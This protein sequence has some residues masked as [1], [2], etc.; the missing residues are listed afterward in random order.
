MT[1]IQQHYYKCGNKIFTSKINALIAAKA[2]GR[3]VD[4][5]F[6]DDI[7]KKYSWDVEPDVSLDALYDIRARELR[8]KY[9]YLIISYSGGSDSHNVVQ[10]FIRQNLHIDELVTNHWS[11]VSKSTTVLDT[12]V[13]ENWNINAE[14]ELQA[15]PR[16]KELSEKLPRTKITVLDASQTI[17]DSMASYDD[18]SWIMNKNDYLSFGHLFRYNYFY[19]NELKKQFDKNL[20]IGVIL[21]A[22][23]P[24]TKIVDNE[25]YVYFPDNAVNIVTIKDHKVG[26]DD[27]DNLT[28]EMFYWG[29]TTA[30][31]VCKQ[32]YVIKRWLEQNPDK[33][34]LWINP[35]GETVRLYHEK[36]M[37]KLLYTTTWNQDWFQ[38][39]KS[40]DWW[41]SQFDY[42]NRHPQ[43]AKEFANWERGIN[44][45]A[46]HLSEWIIL[47]KDNKPDRFKTFT[48]TYK[49]GKMHNEKPRLIV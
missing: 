16:L 1:P 17:L 15:M 38:T 24:R 19:F 46:K 43:F 33:Q 9:D 32:A 20:K 18:E 39:D 8:E 31:I 14:H 42:W 41:Y 21:G 5:L 48:K 27:H 37:R 13:T 4:W 25:F 34:A 40:T 49:I 26:N 29:E 10:S 28:V 2:T 47:N 11:G 7:Y 23:K 3:P 22:E 36:Y 45:V 6:H 12:T 35:T 44:Y 30:P